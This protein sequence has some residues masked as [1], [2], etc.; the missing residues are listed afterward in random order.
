MCAQAEGD[1]WGYYKSLFDNQARLSETLMLDLAQERG[2]DRNAFKNCLDDEGM[3]QRV[4]DDVVRGM[5]ISVGQT[6]TVFLNG[7]RVDVWHNEAL[8]DMLIQ[9]KILETES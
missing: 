4:R 3:Q 5:S 8:L 1:F 2:W 9:Q 7:E 6:P